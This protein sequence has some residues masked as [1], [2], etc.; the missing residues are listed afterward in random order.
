MPESWVSMTVRETVYDRLKSNKQEEESFS[1]LLDRLL[2]HSVEVE[3][4][5]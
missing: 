5:P 1:D 4:E 2:L 3:D